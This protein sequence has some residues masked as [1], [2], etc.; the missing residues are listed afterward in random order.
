M[1]SLPI[2]FISFLIVVFFSVGRLDL[3]IF[4][5]LHSI[6][7]VFFGTLAILAFSTPLS[8]LKNLGKSLLEL[9]KKEPNG[10]Q[11][12]KDLLEI[13]K[14][15]NSPVD[16]Q[17]SLIL[18]AQELW[19]KGVDQEVFVRL[20]SN[21]LNELNS[22]QEAPSMTLRNI[23]KYPPSLG[24]MGTVIGMISLF[25]SLN[26]DNKSLI[27]P[28]LALAMTATF[29]GLILSNGFIMPIADRLQSRGN[30]SMRYAE[31]ILKLILLIHQGEAPKMIEDELN[32]LQF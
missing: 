10:V 20:V 2:G 5:N 6:I 24:M 22:Q 27:G 14:N 26:A 19:Q 17:N 12:K 28:L 23:A 30:T 32:G 13:S 18:Y 1:M 25:S 21:F 9:L 29:Y 4:V 3:R 8:E 31:Q 16:S 7:L 15:R 11:I